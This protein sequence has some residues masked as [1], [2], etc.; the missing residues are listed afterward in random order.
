MKRIKRRK[1]IRKMRN[2][3]LKA[4]ILVAC[5]LLV[6]IVCQWVTMLAEV[7]G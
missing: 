7:I 2:A 5:M 1:H 6:L 3:V 4:L